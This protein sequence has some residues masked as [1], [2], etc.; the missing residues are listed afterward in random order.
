MPS[1]SYYEEQA[2]LLSEWAETAS[3]PDIALRLVVRAR[4]MLERAR[5][6]AA[7]PHDSFYD[8]IDASPPRPPTP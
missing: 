3:S 8:P 7:D 2:R 5:E 6:A 1:A 4:D